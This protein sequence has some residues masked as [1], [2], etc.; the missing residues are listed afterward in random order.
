M[1]CAPV[2]RS[3]LGRAAAAGETESD[4]CPGSSRDVA[5]PALPGVKVHESR[6]Y[7]P[8]RDLHPAATAAADQDRAIGHRRG[9]LESRNSRTA[10]GL[11]AAVVQQRLAL[12]RPVLTDELAD[13]AASVRHC[14][15]LRSSPRGHFWRKRRGLSEI[16][17]LSRSAGR[18]GLPEPL[19]QRMR[20]DSA[21]RRRYLDAEFRRSRRVDRCRRG[22]R[23]RPP[24]RPA[25]TGTTWTGRTP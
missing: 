14:K 1:R 11:L 24:A 21:G 6:R 4:P 8:G 20:R 12:A 10:C 13:A 17:F 3:K 16:D 18:H 9:C 15:V 23:R 25:P 22:R 7:E 2:P 5:V 19:R